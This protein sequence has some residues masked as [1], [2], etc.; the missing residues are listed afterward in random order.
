ME[1]T[2]QANQVKFKNYTLDGSPYGFTI[3]PIGRAISFWRVP[4]LGILSVVTLS[5]DFSEL[6]SS[7][8]TVG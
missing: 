3:I 8:Y 4:V 6:Y 1:F 5:R 2:L 7:L